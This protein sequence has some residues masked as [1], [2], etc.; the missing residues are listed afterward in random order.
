MPSE[1]GTI[2]LMGSGEL[3]A[4]MVEVHKELLS[5]FSESPTAVFLDTPAG[6]QLNV[7]QI[8]DKAVDYFQAHVQQSLTVASF[9]SME[10]ATPLEVEKALQHLR[11]ADYILIGPGSPTYAVRQLSPSPVPDIV[12]NRIRAGG[13]LVAASAAAL[14]VG[15]LTLPVYEIYKVGA[16]LHW[17]D[18]LDILKRFGFNLVVVPHWNNAEGGTH[19]TRY[20]FMGQTRFLQ[21]ESLLPSDVAILGLDE[22]TACIIDLQ[23]QIAQVRGIGRVVLRRSGKEVEFK[24]GDRVPIE[25]LRGKPVQVEWTPAAPTSTGND[26]LSAGIQ[27]EDASFWNRIHGIESEFQEGIRQHDPSAITSALLE[28][29]RSIWQAQQHLENEETISQAREILRDSI[30]QLGTRMATLPRSQEDCLTPLVKELLRA[31]DRFRQ[32]KQW[33]AADAIRD[34]LANAGI[35]VEDT[36]DRSRWH[37]RPDKY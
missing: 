9:K 16:E 30:V 32:G 12:A 7:D 23:K 17:V 35:V 33:D 8:S 4:T 25:L 2:V 19:D 5:H 1:N 13:C 37:L 27:N 31:R 11:S 26:T 15:K 36:P 29:D 24:K 28:L 21:L 10:G 6:F 3:T 20:C 18:G 34:A 14:T 22:H